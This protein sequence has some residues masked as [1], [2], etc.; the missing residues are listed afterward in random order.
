MSITLSIPLGRRQLRYLKKLD[1]IEIPTL[2]HPNRF[3][4]N[5]AIDFVVSA[6][7]LGEFDGPIMIVDFGITDWFKDKVKDFNV[8]YY[9]P[10]DPK[11]KHIINDRF[12]QYLHMI[13]DGAVKTDGVVLY[14]A[15][16]WFQRPIYRIEEFFP[17]DGVLFAP[18]GDP[19]RK[20]KKEELLWPYFGPPHLAEEYDAK[21]RFMSDLTGRVI[22]GGMLG[23]TVPNIKHKL[24]Q[25]D[26]FISM[27]GIVDS[28]KLETCVLT[29]IYDKEKDS[30][31]GMNFNSHVL[32]RMLEDPDREFLRD[33][34]GENATTI[35]MCGKA[36]KNPIHWFRYRHSEI[37]KEHI[38]DGDPLISSD[39]HQ[40]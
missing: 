20:K 21:V 15:D 18:G 19:K 12:T 10:R 34:T 22:S 31:G 28:W 17:K 7:T 2:P 23:G 37:F 16:I 3:N 4:E 8:S 35:H 36:K 27:D 32:R 13:E 6:R 40:Q 25:Y 24:Q 9:Q 30:V 5:M 14:D 11:S 26:D 29:Y 39:P 33:K 38:D 1:K